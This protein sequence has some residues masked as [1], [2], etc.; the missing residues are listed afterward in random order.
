MMAGFGHFGS[1]LIVT[2]TPEGKVVGCEVAHAAHTK[3]TFSAPGDIKCSDFKI[4]DGKIQGKLATDGEQK[5]FGQTWEVNLKF[6]T[7]AP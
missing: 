6:E 1:A 7:P 2:L 5:T 4:A 3:G